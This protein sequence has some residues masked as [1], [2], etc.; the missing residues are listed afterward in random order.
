MIV[1]EGG[2]ALRFDELAIRHGVK[3]VLNVMASLGMLPTRQAGQQPAE[4]KVAVAK[5]T[6]WIRAPMSGM[7]THPRPLGSRV[8][9]DQQLALIVD[10]LGDEET[11]VKAPAEGVIIGKSNIPLTNKGDA[12]FHLALFENLSDLHLP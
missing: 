9:Q 5:S 12:L 1:Y 2:E 10:P 3:G 11:V 8:Y 6:Y 7:V 4:N